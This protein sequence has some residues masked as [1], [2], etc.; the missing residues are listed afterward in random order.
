MRVFFAAQAIAGGTWWI[1]VFA[2]D[3]VGRWTL[4]SWN[5]LLLVVPDLILFVGASALIA[6]TLDRRIAL[7]CATWTT[8]I[9]VALVADALLRRQAGWGALIMTFAT[10]ATLTASVTVWFGALP[11]QWFFIGPFAFRESTATSGAAHVRSGFA[12]LVVFW[13]AFLVV[14]PLILSWTENRIRIEWPALRDT[15]LDAIGLTMFAVGSALG[16]SS[17]FAMT[18][19][20]EGT[21]LP[22]KTARRLVFVGPYRFVRNP[23]AVAGAAQTVGVGLL[24]GAWTV[25]AAAVA[26]S[27]VWNF[28]VRP[29]E[30]A[31]L[32]ARFGDPYVEYA[33]QVR[34][35]VPTVPRGASDR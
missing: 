10:G 5:P 31:D 21:P 25:I 23:M 24:L 26:G 33:R 6:V 34:C 14:L 35:W 20:G 18:L 17:C 27:L 7:L 29:D 28:F 16:L 8:A 11:R 32:A 15:D 22:A 13:T 9:T 3:D 2:S 30:E 1:S 19:F 4:G 12:Q